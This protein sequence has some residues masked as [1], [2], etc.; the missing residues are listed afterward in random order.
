MKW[1]DLFY[2]TKMEMISRR[3]YG[4]E[5]LKTID[6]EPKPYAVRERVAPV[7]GEEPPRARTQ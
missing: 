3:A 5:T 7:I 1:K 4:L 2:F 6:L